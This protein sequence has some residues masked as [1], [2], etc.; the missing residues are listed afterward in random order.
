MGILKV[1]MAYL[2]HILGDSCESPS[3]VL[4]TVLLQF[5]GN[6]QNKPGGFDDYATPTS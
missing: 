1:K 2:A 5:W 6:V 3:L 4:A